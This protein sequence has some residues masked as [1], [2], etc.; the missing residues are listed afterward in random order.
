MVD[1]ERSAA[2]DLLDLGPDPVLPRGVGGEE[3][4]RP[5]QQKRRRIVA[6]EEEGLALVHD[7]L[8]I[9]VAGF[10]LLH[11]VQQHSEQV[12]PVRTAP[13]DLYAVFP[14]LYYLHQQPLHLAFQ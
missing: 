12:V 13:S 11:L 14:A 3:H 7:D 8:Q 5:R 4:D 6:G 9:E 1:R 10:V 2:A